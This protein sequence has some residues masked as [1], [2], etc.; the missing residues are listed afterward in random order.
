MLILA[1]AAL[2]AVRSDSD[3]VYASPVVRQVVERSAAA[4][5]A[6]PPELRGYRA[7][8]ETELSFLVRDTLG[9]EHA[10]QIEQLAANAT[11]TR[12]VCYDLHVVSFRSQSVGVPFSALSFVRGWTVPL[13]YGN[14]L[15]FGIEGGGRGALGAGRARG[16]RD[17]IPVIHPLG[18]ER[19]RY[20]RFGGGDTVAVLHTAAREVP[21]VRI[22]VVPRFDVG[23]R[24]AGFRGELDVDGDRG[25]VVRM[26]GRIVYP[27][28]SRGRRLG[29]LVARAAGVVSAAYVEFEM[30]EVAGRYWLPVYERTEF[31]AT[32]ATFGA[33]RSVFRIVSRF[34]DYS[35]DTASA[36]APTGPALALTPRVTFAPG[37]SISAFTGWREGLGRETAMVTGGDFEELA[38]DPWRPTGAPRLSPYPRR[39]DEVLRYDRVE[40]PFTGLA[41]ALRFRDAAPGLTARAFGGWAWD[42]RTVRGGAAL[43]LARA[44]WTYGV[45]VERSLA[46]TN[47]FRSALEG[48]GSLAALLASVDDA[49]YVDRRT[50]AGSVVRDIGSR[51]RTIVSAE[52]GVGEDRPEVA[53]VA[54]GLFGGPSFRPNRGATAGRYAR[55]AADIELHPNVSGDFV[56]TGVGARARVEYARGELEW[57]RA[58]LSLSGREYRGDAWLAARA[59]GGIVLG[60]ALPPQ[61]L[62][63]LGGNEGL[64]GYGYKEFGGDR[65]AVAALAAGYTLPVLRSP[66]R[67]IRGYYLPGLSPGMAAG[68]QGGWAGAGTAAAWRALRLLGRSGPA[69]YAT[70]VSVP[71]HGIR[72]SVDLRLTLFSGAASVGVARPVDHGAGWRVVVGVGEGY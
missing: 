58:E 63:E 32:A 49:D 13:L 40:G 33:D 19:E 43:T 37:D 3:S 59:R 15:R 28:P 52:I 11:W 66:L 27:D 72:A 46:S 17:T 20:Y 71:T 65:A 70:P 68:I 23:A 67:L 16:R 50:V 14:E 8:V 35:V 54:R 6:P 47:D 22:T 21:I 1:L 36:P 7:R 2:L 55:A 60:E 39:L 61:Q 62:F 29:A 9:R 51:E 44:R 42:E 31:Q 10:T 38:P 41:A 5:A 48:G 25:V 30:E 53:R 12:G 57:T 24:V 26:R 64:P 69:P 34:A 4:N 18:A 45:R 56:E